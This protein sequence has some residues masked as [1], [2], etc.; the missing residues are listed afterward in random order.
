MN[1][2]R[3]HRCA[4][5]G[6][7]ELESGMIQSCTLGEPGFARPWFCSMMDLQLAQFEAGRTEAFVG[8]FPVYID[9]LR[10]FHPAIYSVRYGDDVK[11]I[12][13]RQ[14]LQTIVGETT[15]IN[16]K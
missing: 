5:C 8:G 16:Q 10:R 7:Q 13:Q 6:R 4:Y 1:D 15:E 12:R 3:A 9:C 14:Q 2:N 11:S